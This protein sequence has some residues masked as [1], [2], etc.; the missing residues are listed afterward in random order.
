MQSPKVI[1]YLKTFSENDW[2][3]FVSYA[4][5]VYA[6]SSSQAQVISY[7]K[8]NKSRL[9]RPD[10]DRLKLL[11][12]IKPRLT[13][14]ALSNVLVKLKTAIDGYFVY[15]EVM[16]N[17]FQSRNLL[18]QSYAKRGLKK[19]FFKLKADMNNSINEA[20][21]SL[22]DD[23]YKLQIEHLTYF[24][25][26]T[27]TV[28]DSR[29]ILEGTIFSINSFYDKLASFYEL[30]LVNREVTIKENWSE[31]NPKLKPH[32]STDEISHICTQ[33]ISLK[34]NRDR[35]SYNFL[36]NILENEQSKFSKSIKYAI[37]IHLTSYL[38]HQIKIGDLH[39]NKELLSLYKGGI[40]S[41]LLINNGRIPSRRFY[42]ILNLA[43]GSKAFDWA[44]DFVEQY[45]QL[46]DPSS[47][48]ETKILAKSEINFKKGNYDWV[49]DK[50]V[51]IKY[52]NF[53]H[54]LK[55]RWLLICSEFELNRDNI[56]FI[57]DRVRSMNYY[58][59]RNE[60][61]MDVF[62]YEGVKNLCK[63]LVKL[64]KP[65]DPALI[66]N[67]IIE[68]EYLVYRGWLLSKLKK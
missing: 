3:S 21:I 36:L 59:K 11:D 18:M 32:H 15:S 53:D 7:Y 41:G 9:N 45:A 43:C 60:K 38:N 23:F 25:N 13:A 42:N 62:A 39:L 28:A 57:E 29:K 22:W 63:F 17:E 8:S 14:H 58:L 44:E 26:M 6:A 30:E 49:I 55:A 65:N 66:E 50:L 64:A 1:S 33:L 61:N 16:N 52:R 40:D 67:E 56:P 5:S 10:W 48:Q 27:N 47:E 4:K 20:P 24:E 37:L 54:E 19:D 46:V 34:R 31:E 12:S 35:K 51:T 68:T 2:K